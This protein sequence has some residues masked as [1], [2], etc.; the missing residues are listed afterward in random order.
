MT[1]ETRRLNPL[2][3]AAALILG[4]IIGSIIFFIITLAIGTINNLLGT[5]LTVTADIAENLFSLALL[6]ILILVCCAAFVWKV[7]VT[8]SSGD[9]AADADVA[10]E[11]EPE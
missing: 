2:R 10:D 5:N 6:A 9:E 7:S 8:P 4:F 1:E 3:V 11:E